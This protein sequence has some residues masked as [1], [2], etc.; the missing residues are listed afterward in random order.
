MPAAVLQVAQSIEDTLDLFRNDVYSP[1]A[2]GQIARRITSLEEENESVMMERLVMTRIYS[3]AVTT[4][5]TEFSQSII[6]SMLKGLLDGQCYSFATTMSVAMHRGP[7]AV[8]AFVARIRA[9]E[10][11]RAHSPTGA[12]AAE[13]LVLS[14]E[15]RNVLST[16]AE[17]S[18]LQPRS[19]MHSPVAS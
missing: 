17:L 2:R 13:R 9:F 1:R 5:R 8:R 19:P 10:A 18:L 11:L 3:R 14:A 15:S 6:P 16:L 4:A 7:Q 12:E